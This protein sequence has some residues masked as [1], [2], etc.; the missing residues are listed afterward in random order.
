[1]LTL[2]KYKAYAGIFLM[3]N[4]TFS[5][6]VIRHKCMVRNNRTKMIQQNCRRS[7]NPQRSPPQVFYN[8]FQSLSADRQTAGGSWVRKHIRPPSAHIAAIHLHS[9][10]AAAAAA[11]AAAAMETLYGA[12]VIGWGGSPIDDGAGVAAALH[13]SDASDWYAS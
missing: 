12:N 13:A 1:M 8:T 4:M 7:A 2:G 9:F 6:A 5:A 10:N 11:A 3:K